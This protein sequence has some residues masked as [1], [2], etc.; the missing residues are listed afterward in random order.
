MTIEAALRSGQD[1]I[2]RRLLTERLGGR[3]G[4]NRFAEERLDRL[5]A[6]KTRGGGPLGL[7][8]SLAFARPAH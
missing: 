6:S 1:G 7:V 5:M 8:A 2:A 3:N 4:N